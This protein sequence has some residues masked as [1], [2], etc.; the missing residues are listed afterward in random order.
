MNGKWFVV[1]GRPG[2]GKST[3]VKE[4]RQAGDFVWDFDG[5]RRTVF[6]ADR[7]LGKS[8]RGLLVAM[9][10][11][12]VSRL[13][14]SDFTGRVWIIIT[15][16]VWASRTAER[17]GGEVVTLDVDRKVCRDR[18]LERDEAGV[19]RDARLAKIVQW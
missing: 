17:I 15:D 8:E 12:A 7:A 10:D 19:E 4:R 18:V 2:A 1:T 6:G 3:Y 14:A 13:P 11:A 16:R 5:V 9:L